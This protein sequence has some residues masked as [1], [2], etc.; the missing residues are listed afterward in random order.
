MENVTVW[1][2]TGHGMTGLGKSDA[3]AFRVR[4]QQLNQNRPRRTSSKVC[5]PARPVP[6]GTVTLTA[7]F[8]IHSRRRDLNSMRKVRIES[9]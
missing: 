4:R 3:E 6:S 7:Y 1:C 8:V 9:H 5:R 2:P